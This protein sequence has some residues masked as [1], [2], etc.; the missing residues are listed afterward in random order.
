MLQPRVRWK[1]G[2]KDVKIECLISPLLFTIVP[3]PILVKLHNMAIEEEL[4]GI[5]LQSG[6]PYIVQALTDDHIMFLA[7]NQENISCQYQE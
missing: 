6:K 5:M 1:D 4:F 3:L 7:P 2:W